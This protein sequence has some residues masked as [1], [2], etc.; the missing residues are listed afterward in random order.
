VHLGADLS[1]CAGICWQDEYGLIRYL[2][3]WE[4]TADELT[5]LFKLLDFDKWLKYWTYAHRRS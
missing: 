1:D 2:N 4:M 3:F 5:V